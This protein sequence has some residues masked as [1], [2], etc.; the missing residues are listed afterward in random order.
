MIKLIKMNKLSNDTG[1]SVG[2]IAIIFGVFVISLLFINLFLL[3]QILGIGI[4]FT[5]IWLLISSI[6]AYKYSKSESIVY[7]I[8]SIISIVT[9]LGLYLNLTSYWLYGSRWIYLTG[10]IILITSIIAFL[11]PSKIEKAAGIMGVI[12]GILF[13][14]LYLYAANLY[15]L[16]II[17][18]IWLIIIGII[19]FVITSD[20]TW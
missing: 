17:T 9:G 16:V 1:K 8:L 3:N 6:D 20:E 18:G 7:L 2:I 12:L 19:Q 11:G 13:L 10:L 14:S 4:L 15:V 5:G